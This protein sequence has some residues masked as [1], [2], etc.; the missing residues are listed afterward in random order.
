M[1]PMDRTLDRRFFASAAVLLCFV[2]FVG[3]A[4]NYYLRAW[5]GTRPLT[6]LAHVHGLVMTAW[7][8]L[9]AVQTFLISRRRVARH[10]QL[11]YWVGALAAVVVLL[12]VV[13]IAAA[14]A[15]RRPG[16]DLGTALWVFVAYDGLSVLL[17]A[18]LVA[19][20]IA[21]RGAP[22]AHKRLML[23]AMLSL[24]PPAFGR[25]VAYF[26]HTDV[27]I[28]VLC[29]MYASVLIVICADRFRTR[30]LCASLLVPALLIVVVNQLTYFAQVYE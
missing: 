3:F 17:F 30:R 6:L 11:G 20:A 22:W 16:V 14:I 27:A 4:R 5:I 10:Q 2:M 21:R 13:T 29:L 18:G 15:R 12:G 25:L 1:M 28:I 19:A 9:F 24:L 8:A 23:M 7:V 26:T